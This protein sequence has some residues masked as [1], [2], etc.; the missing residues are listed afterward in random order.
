LSIEK[1]YN[2]EKKNDRNLG[3]TLKN[4]FKELGNF[5]FLKLKSPFTIIGLAMVIFMI[6]VSIFPMIITPYSLSQAQGIYSPYYGA[7]SP[8]H[9]L[10][11]TKFGRDVLAGIVYAIPN[12]LIFGI[13]TVLIG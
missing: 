3:M 7:P 6:L 9:P 11:T 5:L 8:T 12:S 13:I 4:Q 1:D 2:K 10:G